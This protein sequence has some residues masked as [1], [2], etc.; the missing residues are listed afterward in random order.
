MV[1]EHT[2]ISRPKNLDLLTSSNSKANCDLMNNDGA[3]FDSSCFSSL[4]NS[5]LNRLPTRFQNAQSFSVYSS[6]SNLNSNSPGEHS[7]LPSHNL[8]ESNLQNRSLWGSM[9]KSAQNQTS[10]SSL[11]NDMFDSQTTGIFNDVAVDNQVKANSVG[12]IGSGLTNGHIDNKDD[13][14]FEASPFTK[15]RSNSKDIWHHGKDHTSTSFFTA[16]GHNND[17]LSPEKNASKS[18]TKSN[19][20]LSSDMLPWKLNPSDPITVLPGTW[21]SP[22]ESINNSESAFEEQSK[23][24]GGRLENFKK[25]FNSNDNQDNSTSWME[26]TCKGRSS[27]VNKV[28]EILENFIQVGFCIDVSFYLY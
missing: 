2:P 7:V 17:F 25:L 6:F 15:S 26:Q 13:S 3:K 19:L 16:N 9:S 27:S 11:F 10:R 24:D 20:N 1:N 21:S 23:M 5:T 18:T 22:A 14:I 8:L 12:E 28:M 4:N